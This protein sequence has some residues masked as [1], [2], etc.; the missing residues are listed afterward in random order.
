[1][2]EA[3]QW[4]VESCDRGGL[5]KDHWSPHVSHE[6]S[7]QHCEPS[8]GNPKMICSGRGITN[9]SDQGEMK[10]CVI[11]SIWLWDTT[12]SRQMQ[13]RPLHSHPGPRQGLGKWSGRRPTC[14]PPCL[15]VIKWPVVGCM[16]WF[17]L[18]YEVLKESVIEGTD[19][20]QARAL[21]DPLKA[22]EIW[23]PHKCTV[24]FKKRVNNSLI[25]MRRDTA[26]H[27]RMSNSLIN[28]GSDGVRAF[29]TVTLA[30]CGK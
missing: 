3:V 20:T 21:Y 29:W 7:Q 1:M 27:Q 22:L 17:A 9:D 24:L 28:S 15:S 4:Y 2:A 16:C 14:S 25:K 30:D 23:G 19:A 5:W 10:A 26:R 11:I 13:Q 8:I 6:A 18:V 12:Y